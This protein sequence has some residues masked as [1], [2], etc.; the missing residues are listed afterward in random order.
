MN[1]LLEVGKWLDDNKDYQLSTKE[2]YEEFVEKRN[3]KFSF[4]GDALGFDRAKSIEVDNSVGDDRK[5]SKKSK[6]K[7]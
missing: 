5:S 4:D 7:R 1:P 2:K 3:Y 6:R